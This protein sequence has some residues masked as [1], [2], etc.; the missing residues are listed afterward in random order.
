MLT[1]LAF[2][3]LVI[4]AAISVVMHRRGRATELARIREGWTKPIDRVRKMDAIAE[5]HLSLVA[6]DPASSLDDRTWNDLDLDA[7]FATLDR[8]ESTLGQQAL[9]HRLRTTPHGAHLESFE[10]LVNRMG[11]DPKGRERAQVAL[12]RLH[13]PAGYDLWWLVQ[14]GTLETRPWHILFPLVAASNLAALALVPIWHVAFVVPV[15]GIV[16]NLILRIVTARR[17]SAVVGA[18]RQVGPAIAVARAL[19]VLAES[20]DDPILLPLHSDLPRLARLNNIARWVGRDPTAAGELVGALFEWMNMLFLLHANALYFGARELRL[21]GP[22]LLRVVGAVG[23]IDAA[24]A[25]ASWRAGT[26]GW[27]RPRFHSDEALASVTD[28][29]HPLLNHAV[30]NSIVLGPPYGVLVTGSNMSGK[31]TFLRTIGVNAVMAQTIHTCLATAYNAPVSRVRSCIGRSDDL[32]AGKSYYIDEVDAVLALV[33]AS[34]TGFPHIFLLD[35][36]FRGTNA[37]ERIAA[38]EAV[39]R[40][41]I[42]DGD[43]VRSSIV[44]ASTHDGELVELLGDSYAPY[45][46]AD[47]IGPAGLVFEYRLAHGPATTRNAI[48]LLELRGAPERV[49]SRAMK[50]AAELDQQKHLASERS[51]T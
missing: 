16:V 5:Y 17:V 48:A 28:I 10:A 37:V 21:N 27:S 47:T 19:T 20:D 30:P 34:Q 2:G 7:V 40:E 1:P 38:A 22:S 42:A 25:V 4:A 29:R 39:L 8:T 44:L 31:S 35:E 11:G 41:L 9:Y 14:P 3:A 49:V 46:F 32:I 13:D 43:R 51:N 15:A 23:E 36:L 6:S 50:R 26:S 18:F 33:R 24:I 12:A 45:H